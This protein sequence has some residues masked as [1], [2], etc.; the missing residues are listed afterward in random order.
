MMTIFQ[1]INLSSWEA[2]LSLTKIK[3]PCARWLISY[4]LLGLVLFLVVMGL[5]LN[6]QQA[7]KSL[8]LDYLFPRSW[9]SL[10]ETLISFLYDSQAK[11]V[12]SNLILS[13]SLVFSSI[14]LFPIKEK[15]SAEFER[16]GGYSC[17]NIQEF[18][19][20]YQALEE[21]KL[22]LL[23]LTSQLIILWIGYYPYTWATNL[24][25]VLSYLFLFFT[26]ALDFI[27][28]TYQRHRKKYA[29]IIKLLL[30][31]PVVSLTFG[32]IFSL[33]A[34][35]L[36]QWVISQQDYSLV[37]IV[38]ILFIANLFLLALAIPAGTHVACRLFPVLDQIKQPT[39]KSR[40]IG[41]GLLS[42][43]LVLGLLLHS[44]LLLSLHHKSQLL[45]AEYDIDWS[46]FR[47][48]LPDFKSLIEQQSQSNL[49][50]AIVITNP[51]QFDIQIE[52]S[53]ILIVQQDSNIAKIDIEG[54]S[55]AA[56]QK[57]RIEL[58]FKADSNLSLTSQWT[59]IFSGWRIDWMV[60]IWPRIP[61]CD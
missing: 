25:I 49:S 18:P 32:L 17:G 22:F 9:H 35:I 27:A 60:D 5:Y 10:S 61:L 19:L 54:F 48:Q 7:I 3:K 23:Y 4:I 16:G 42:L 34:I 50:F 29:R 51:T 31:K 56:G 11:S 30:S 37:K 47:Y 45:K 13:S 44:R 28:P 26:L 2:I 14:F 40:V 21:T 15:Y 36:G 59:N 1:Q 20:L 46:S 8:L 39:K 55:I 43:F 24:S 53:Y 12:I 52:P 33:P 6:Y 58:K 38:S 57:K 41:Y